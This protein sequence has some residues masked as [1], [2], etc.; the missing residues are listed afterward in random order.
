M[1]GKR[2]GERLDFYLLRME[3]VS[4]YKK[5]AYNDQKKTVSL[6]KRIVS[7]KSILVRQEKQNK[8]FKLFVS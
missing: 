8:S 2:G 4:L 5:Q 1:T 3:L 6:K 7:N